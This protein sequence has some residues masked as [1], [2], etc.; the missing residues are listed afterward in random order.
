MPSAKWFCSVWILASDVESQRGLDLTRQWGGVLLP[1]TEYEF[2]CVFP[3]ERPDGLCCPDV[4][5]RIRSFYLLRLL[6]QCGAVGLRRTS[7][8]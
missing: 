4:F 7:V 1:V 2:V 6:L 5:A 3:T 8:L